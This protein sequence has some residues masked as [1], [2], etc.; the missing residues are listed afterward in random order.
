MAKQII[1]T[2]NNYGI[3][4]ETQ[5]LDSNKNPIDLTNYCVEVKIEN[6]GTILDVA[7]AEITGTLASII[8][9]KKH[10]KEIGLYKTEWCVM[11]LDKKITAQEDIYYFVK[12]EVSADGNEGE[13]QEINI[14]AQGVV[15]K[16]KELDET[17][18][19]HGK[20]LTEIT[21]EI[22]GARGINLNL[23]ERLDNFS[24]C[25]D[26]IVNEHLEKSVKDFGAKG[27]GVTDDTQSI[28]DAINYC[29][30]NKIT[31]LFP[32][33]TYCYTDLGNVNFPYLRMIG[34][35]DKEVILKCINTDFNHIA[36][37]INAF[38]SDANTPILFGIKIENIVIECNNDTLIGLQIQGYARLDIKNVGIKGLGGAGTKCFNILG[39][40]ECNFFNLYHG[41]NYLGVEN[42]IPQ[43]GL[44]L[45]RSVRGGV[46][47]GSSTNNNFVN[48]YF[49]N[50]VTG[51]ELLYADQNTFTTCAS[52]ANTNGV[53]INANGVM[54]NFIALA[55]EKNTSKL[56]IED[57]GRTNNFINCYT[58][59]TMKANGRQGSILGG[60][61]T[62]LILG[63]DGYFVNGIRVNNR[64]IDD[65]GFQM[66]GNG[67]TIKSI[68]DLN[69]TVNNY[70][71]PLA[72]R[73][74]IAVTGSPFTFTNTTG[75]MIEVICQSGTAS[76]VQKSRGGNTYVVSNQLPNT[77]LLA[78]TESL[79]I[80]YSTAP[81]MSYVTYNGY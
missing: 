48:C 57:L 50:C 80:T 25:L 56:D 79:I 64:G 45:D 70:I 23:K 65:G 55:T 58:E 36:L 77:Y 29:Y 12:A 11:D 67:N 32:R 34:S 61:I 14:D 46:V 51:V 1:V 66:D 37:N 28:I 2:Q 18:F 13:N 81:S 41:H 43:Y 47:E 39:C 53:K 16:F 42:I 7:T 52:Q 20:K 75:N 24:L 69:S 9:N 76:M 4:L 73:K 30:N 19:E 10:T 17:F 27:D 74:S 71:Y 49:E 68:L 72:P 54:N 59:Y 63:G 40:H 35:G 26:N 60:K 21:E 44:Y 22:K 5:F 3:V 78:P 38:T 15:N 62:N 6:N 8:L 33:G 31:L